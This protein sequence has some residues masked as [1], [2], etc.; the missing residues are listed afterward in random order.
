M[1]GGPGTF[2]K[3]MEGRP[4]PF[5]KGF[6]GQAGPRR[7]SSRQAKIVSRSEASTRK[8]RPFPDHFQT[9]CYF[10]SADSLDRWANSFH[11]AKLR[12]KLCNFVRKTVHACSNTSSV[13]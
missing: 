1:E 10:A 5:A 13:A 9:G 2:A 12:Q 3:A 4:V 11:E 7:A 8:T 6:G